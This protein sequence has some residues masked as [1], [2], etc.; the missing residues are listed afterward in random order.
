MIRAILFDFNGVVI[1]DEPLQQKAYQQVLQPEGIALT[2]GE[3]FDCLGMDDV[4]FVRAAFARAGREVEDE[5]L[6]RV[7]EGKTE[8]HRELIKD[9]LPLFPGVVTFIKACAR[10]WPLAI[11]SM[12][13]RVEIDHVLERAGLSQVF[14]AIVSAEDVQACKPDPACCLRALELLNEKARGA[15]TSSLAAAE[16]LVIEDS[17]PGVEAARAAGMRSLGVTN[18]VA[19][20]RLRAAGADVVTH[21]LADWTPDAVYHVFGKR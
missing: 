8:Q 10:Q 15:N 20:E 12:A 13:R 1:D 4:A 7:I 2:E 3:Y 19:E 16:C 18:T 11:A 21:S 5:Q 14:A 6:R 17:P 9:E